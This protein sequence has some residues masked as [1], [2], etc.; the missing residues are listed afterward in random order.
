MDQLKFTTVA[1]RD[2]LF[3]NPLDSAKIE[4]FLAL[5]DLAP[6][7]R[8]LDV[9]CGKAELLLR[10]MERWQASGVGIDLNAAFLTEAQAT[11]AGRVPAEQL[12]LAQR[13]AASFVAAPGSFDVALCVGSTHALG[14][15]REA[16][17]TLKRW[18]RED[19][20]LLIGEGYWKCEPDQEYLAFLGA[21]RSDL[22]SHE[23]NIALAR[24]AEWR[25]LRAEVSSAEEW[26][27]YEGLYASSIE[28]YV[29]EHP[30]EPESAEWRARIDRWQEAY[31]RWGRRTLGFGLYLLRK[32]SL[33]PFMPV[34]R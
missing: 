34:W 31:Q 30:H 2:H 17:S 28:Q 23:G 12:E 26:D 25:L 16:L 19:G 10:H 13:D 29:S 20:Y 4:R 7:A 18:V 3:C 32:T 15:Y 8:A 1:H 21:A 6:G 5:L 14:G 11:A 22:L 33:P 24:A 27:A 9:G